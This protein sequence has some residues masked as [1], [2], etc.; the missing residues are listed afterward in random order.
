VQA[1]GAEADRR[2]GGVV[3]ELAWG[4]RESHASTV[5]MSR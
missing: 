1:G 5:S 2:D 4:G 3:V